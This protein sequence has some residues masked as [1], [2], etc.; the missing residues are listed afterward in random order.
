MQADVKW[1]GMVSDEVLIALHG[2]VTDGLLTAFNKLG[3]PIKGC[4]INIRV[5]CRDECQIKNFSVSHYASFF[6]AN[7][8]CCISRNILNLQ[9]WKPAIRGL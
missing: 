7:A 8:W 1:F 4:V 9:R 5:L 3:L 6:E 2:I